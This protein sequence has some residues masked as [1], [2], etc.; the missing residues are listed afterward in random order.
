MGADT[1]QLATFCDDDYETRYRDWFDLDELQH[2]LQSD[3]PHRGY[4]EFLR[5]AGKAIGDRFEQ[6]HDIADLMHARSWA[7]DQVLVHCWQRR[8]GDFGGALVAVGGYGRREL[9]PGSDVDIMVLLPEAEDE[10]TGARLE[11]FL[12]KLWDIGLEV[13]HSV[14][15]LQE[16]QQQARDDIT[17]VTNLM[18]ARW[19]CGSQALSRNCA[20]GSARRRCGPARNSLLPN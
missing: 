7:V 18:E 8:V 4:R 6:D 14:R 9:M 2:A 20:N 10:A 12:G 13:G 15:T 1:G 19:L 3:Q 5:L 16:C 11:T 17:V